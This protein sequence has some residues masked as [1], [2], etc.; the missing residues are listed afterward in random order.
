M[1]DFQR[2]VLAFLAL[3]GKAT[4]FKGEND[5]HHKGRHKGNQVLQTRSAKCGEIHPQVQ[6]GV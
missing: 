6:A 1:P 4:H 2:F 3:R 5:G